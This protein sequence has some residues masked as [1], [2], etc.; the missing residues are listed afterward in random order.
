[1][2]LPT[3]LMVGA[4]WAH[5]VTHVPGIPPAEVLSAA[6]EAMKQTKSL[7]YQGRL[8][9]V[10]GEGPSGAC[11]IMMKRAADE[12]GVGWKLYIGGE[13]TPLGASDP[14]KLQVAFD[15][16]VGRSLKESEKAIAE[17]TAVDA[18][19]LGTFLESQ[20][21]KDLV[22]WNLIS[23]EPLKKDGG[24]I[25]GE[26]TRDVGGEA[27][28]VVLV[29]AGEVGTR[30]YIASADHLPRKIE[31]L[32]SAAGSATQ[33]SPKPAPM[34]VARTLTLSDVKHNVMIAE[35]TFIMDVPDGFT[36]RAIKNPPPKKDEAAG[37]LAGGDRPGGTPPGPRQKTQTPGLLPPG[38]AAPAW[39]LK[40]GDDK[41]ISLADFSGKVV[42]LDFWG[43]WCPPC[44]AALPS[45]Q[46]ISEKYKAK[47]VVVIG[48]NFEQDPDADPKKFMADLGITYKLARGAETIADKYRVPGWP[49]FYVINRAGEIVWGS[50]GFSKAQ[51]EE[52]ERAMSEAID[53]ALA[54]GI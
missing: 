43:S 50:V 32:V 12:R 27:C 9:S 31:M 16:I 49:T 3:L 4:V 1:M 20:S 24:E 52:H 37:K 41:P 14:Q 8:T 26:G 39:T 17:K 44:R 23:G 47:G 19:A 42:V 30:Y 13:I 38:S 40:D 5:G 53:E 29:K 25:T 15:G 48:V 2:L 11:E 51:A 33:K 21:A 45:M 10:A 54:D 34:R 36:V 22:V 46:K 7:A 18:G 6:Q 35:N 28:D